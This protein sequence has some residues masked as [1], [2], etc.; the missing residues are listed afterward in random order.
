MSLIYGSL[1]LNYI[2]LVGATALVVW[3]MQNKKEGHF[4]AKGVGFLIFLL[5]LFSIVITHYTQRTWDITI[6]SVTDQES[7]EVR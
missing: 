6:K 5:A 4:L 2:A 3:S 7:T 1:A